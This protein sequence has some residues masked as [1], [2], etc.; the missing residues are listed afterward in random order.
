MTEAHALLH[1][2][3]HLVA[4]LQG[5]KQVVELR[6]LSRPGLDALQADLVAVVIL[7]RGL[8]DCT[9]RCLHVDVEDALAVE[10]VL[11]DEDILD[12]L[13][14]TGIE[15]H[16]AGYTREAPEV[17]VLQIRAVAPAHHL[18]GDEVLAFLQVL[19]DVELGSHLRVL[20][21]A[22]V[23]AVDPKGEVAGGRAHMEIDILA[24][25]VEGQV[26]LAA[27]GTR[28]VVGL[29]DKRRVAVERRAPRIA[30][31]LV[32]FV[33]I[34]LNLEESGHGEVHPFRVVEGRQEEV[35]GCQV[36]VL[37]EVEAP[38]TLHREET[39]GLRLVVGLRLVG[40]LESEEGGTTGLT[41]Y[42]VHCGVPPGGVYGTKG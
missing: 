13:L 38:L 25:P 16:L 39:L 30:Y 18:H 41:V 3:E 4:L 23:L 19:G 6:N 33:A 37:H 22:H 17:L 8:D 35:L 9:L 21:V 29:V 31:V 10:I 32:D 42:L 28:V 5:D 36:V 20:R 34:A 7:Q 26:E 15:I 1:H 11:R 40:T 2:L 24:F 27:I 12:V 14:G